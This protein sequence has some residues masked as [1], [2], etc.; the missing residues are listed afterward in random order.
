MRTAAANQN[1]KKSKPPPQILG[2]SFEFAVRIVKLCEGLD[3]RRG[4]T[5]ILMPQILRAGTSVVS[6]IE[7]A[8]SGQSRADFVAKMA[9]A[10][11]EAREMHVRLRILSEASVLPDQKLS[12][13]I[14]EADE[15]K[16]I[17]ASIIIAT[18]NGNTLRERET[19]NF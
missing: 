2:R 15:I 5:R 18:K 8:Q 3:E 12:P 13:L 4:V 1:G 19:S 17:L 14:A 7:E 11:K 6:K 9:I 10:L 16:R